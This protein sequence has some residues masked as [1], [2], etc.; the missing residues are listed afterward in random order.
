MMKHNWTRNVRSYDPS[1]ETIVG[2][3]KRLGVPTS[4]FYANRDKAIVEKP[5][6]ADVTD[7]L[8]CPEVSLKIYNQSTKSILS[9]RFSSSF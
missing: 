6:A 4:G 8:V 7:K 2:Y 1:K 5:R 3:C 9:G